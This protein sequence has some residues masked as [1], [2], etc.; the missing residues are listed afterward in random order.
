MAQRVTSRTGSA[1]PLGGR[2][3]GPSWRGRLFPDLPRQARRRGRGA[4]RERR[5]VDA[6]LVFELGPGPDGEGHVAAIAR[7]KAL[8]MDMVENMEK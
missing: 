3:S 1:L 5:L 6:Y 2:G 8:V 7:S 4:R